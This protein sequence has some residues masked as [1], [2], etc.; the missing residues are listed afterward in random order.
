M[1]RAMDGILPSKIQ[2]RVGKTGMGMHF[3]RNMIMLDKKTLEDAIIKDS[4]LI[5]NYVNL[6]Y[7]KRSYDLYKEDYKQGE[8]TDLWLSTLL[9][10]WLKNKTFENSYASSE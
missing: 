3:K 4:E 1:R 7:L 8:T 6:D 5:N 10:I 9:I 2:W